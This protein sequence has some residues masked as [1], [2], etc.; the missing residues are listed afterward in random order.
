MLYEVITEAEANEARD[1]ALTAQAETERQ[2]RVNLAQ[3]LAAMGPTI[4]K[5]SNDN[6]LATLP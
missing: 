4:L 3:S 2:R 6:V 1:D 5:Q